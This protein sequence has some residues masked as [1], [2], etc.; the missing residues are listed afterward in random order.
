MPLSPS[1]QTLESPKGNIN[2]LPIY[3]NVGGGTKTGK[4]KT[5]QQIEQRGTRSRTKS[6][7]AMIHAEAKFALNVKDVLRRV[8]KGRG[9]A[10]GGTTV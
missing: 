5:P 9:R 8:K 3:L 1:E 4:L 2:I 6:M 10:H 7:L